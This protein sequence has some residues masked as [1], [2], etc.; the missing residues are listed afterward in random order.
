MRESKNCIRMAC[1]PYLPGFAR[2][3][4][5]GCLFQRLTVVKVV[6]SFSK[7]SY[8]DFHLIYLTKLGDALS[9]VAL[10]TAMS[11]LKVLYS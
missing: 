2:S 10:S 4:K 3:I 9:A 8:F 5:H 11:L 1:L 7:S 6:N